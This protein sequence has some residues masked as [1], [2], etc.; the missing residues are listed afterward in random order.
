MSKRSVHASSPVIIEDANLSWAWARVVM[1]IQ[2]HAGKNIAPLLVS[3]S[4]FDADGAPHED[5]ALRR[6]LDVLLAQ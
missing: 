1:H 2:E 5:A 4:G 3:V 6:D